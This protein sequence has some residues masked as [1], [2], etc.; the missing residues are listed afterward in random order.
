MLKIG[1]KM[2]IF[3]ENRKIAKKKAL[4]REPNALNSLRINERLD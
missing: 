3:K 4:K 1:K 2:S